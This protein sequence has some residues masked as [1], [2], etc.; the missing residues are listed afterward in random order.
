MRYFKTMILG[1]AL[2][3]GAF[4]AIQSADAQNRDDYYAD[5][6]TYEY[7]QDRA[8]DRSGYRGRTPDHKKDGGAVKGAIGG[9]I[10]GGIFSDKEEDAV[11]GAVLGGIFGGIQREKARE[12]DARKRRDYRYELE[13]CL[14]RRR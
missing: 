5:A 10:L 3:T 8:A 4:I 14:D 2:A 7:C 1:A 11:A 6:D 12:E 13:A 9:A